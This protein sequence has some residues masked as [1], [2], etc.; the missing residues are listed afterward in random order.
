MGYIQS[1][2]SYKELCMKLKLMGI[3]EFPSE[4]VFNIAFG[5][6]KMFGSSAYQWKKFVSAIEYNI[7]NEI[8]LTK[9]TT[10]SLGFL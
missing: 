6:K 9:I 7:T 10:V 2:E 1:V 3:E 8:P 5:Y 4:F